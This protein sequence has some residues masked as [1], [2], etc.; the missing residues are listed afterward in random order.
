MPVSVRTCL[1]A[2]TAVGLVSSLLLTDLRGEDWTQFRGPGGEG[3]SSATRL[4]TQWSATKNVRWKTPIPG[5]GWSS[6]VSLGR[7]IFAT[8]AVASGNRQ[9]LHAIC[10]DG[11]DGKIV[12]DVTVF[13]CLVPEFARQIHAKNSHASPTP[14][15][16][17][18][19]LYVHF[20]AHGTACLSTEG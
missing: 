14:I 13:D 6:P 7:H 10:L 5:K 11:A 20:G 9:E 19:R 15:A 18:H 3:H 17:G 12:W 2:I 1:V 8:T 16:D 4:P